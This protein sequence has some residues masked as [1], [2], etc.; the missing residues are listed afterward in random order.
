M[1]SYHKITKVL[2]VLE[3][4]IINLIIIYF[5]IIS[6]NSIL[7]LINLSKLGYLKSMIYNTYIITFVISLF[8]VAFIG[9]KYKLSFK[10]IYILT[11]FIILFL[12]ISGLLIYNFKILGNLMCCFYLVVI[13]AVVVILINLFNDKINKLYDLAVGSTNINNRKGETKGCKKK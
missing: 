8:V 10:K 11:L 4:V 13:C 6:T 12:P 1:Q 2:K 3:L 7:D 9:I 5:M